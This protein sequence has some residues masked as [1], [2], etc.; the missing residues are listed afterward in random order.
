MEMAKY[1]LILGLFLFYQ[2]ED[3]SAERKRMV[4][5][6]IETR[7]IAD[8]SVLEAMRNVPRHKL[9]PENQA[10][11]AYADRPLPIGQK[12]TISQ[13]YIVAYMTELVQPKK[14]MKVLEIGTGSGYQAA[15]LAEIVDQVYTLEIVPE[16]GEKAKA[17]LGEMG[18]D[19][20]HVRVADGYNGWEEHA[21][22]D[23]IVVTAAADHI[24]P[25]L[26]EQLKEGGKMIIPID[27]GEPAQQ[28]VLVEKTGG[29]ISQSNVLPVRFVPFTRS[30]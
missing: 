1:M 10:K 13:P 16:L 25:S 17:V 30:K 23:A 6:Q 18:Y 9:V 19:N 4:R 24:P 22:F 28:L 29:K 7:G 3:R 27:S 12:Q 2:E 15:V 14:H 21:P 8:P 20:I 5:D 11:F 26:T